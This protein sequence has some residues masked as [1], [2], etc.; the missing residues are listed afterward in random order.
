M[1]YGDFLN[2]LSALRDINHDLGLGWHM[3]KIIRHIFLFLGF[4]F[5]SRVIL[6]EVV[7]MEQAILLALQNSPEVK[8]SKAILMPKV[9]S[10]Y[11]RGSI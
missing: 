10:K 7:T 2:K 11:L 6:A 3:N 4:V 5:C 9:P 1:P 8:I